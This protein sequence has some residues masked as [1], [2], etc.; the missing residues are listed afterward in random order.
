M[1]SSTIEE[2]L[3]LMQRTAQFQ[4]QL[5]VLAAKLMVF[6]AMDESEQSRTLRD[7]DGLSAQHAALVAESE[8]QARA[9]AKTLAELGA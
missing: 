8:R 1:C 2:T 4:A 7:F 5:D 9:F 3:D 6:A